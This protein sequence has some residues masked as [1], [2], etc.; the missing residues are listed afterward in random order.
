M[1]VNGKKALFDTM[2]SEVPAPHPVLAYRRFSDVIPMEI[3]DF[4]EL[5]AVLI[6]HDHY[7]HLDYLSIAKLK[8]KVK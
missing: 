7:D 8:D 3:M 2:L 4:P 1:D 5:D 6:S